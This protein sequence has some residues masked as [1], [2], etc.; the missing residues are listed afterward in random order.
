[1]ILWA[2]ASFGAGQS[3]RVGEETSLPQAAKRI[4]NWTIDG[5]QGI[6]V[7]AASGEWYYGQF[8]GPCVGLRG[9][10]NIAFRFNPNGSLDRFS[11]VL[12]RG[13]PHRVCALKSFVTSAAPPGERHAAPA[14]P[15]PAPAGQ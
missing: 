4:T 5:T 8:L 3:P 1:M 6:W 15:A 11:H 2:G 7:Q 13:R 10:D 14:A 9:S 12:V